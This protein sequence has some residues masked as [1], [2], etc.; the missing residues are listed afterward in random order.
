GMNIYGKGSWANSLKV[1]NGKFYVLTASLD[2]GKTYLFSTED[3]SG[4]W[5]RTEFNEYLHDPALFFDDDGKAYIIYGVEDFSIKELTAD[6]KAINP[7]GLNQVILTSGQ[8]GMEGAHVYKINGKYY[9]TA[10][11]WEQ[12]QIRRQY[13]YRSDQI[14]G[15]YEGRLALSDTMGR[16]EEHTSELQSRENLVCRLLLEKKNIIICQIT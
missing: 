9:I 11:W 3:P 6:Y 5:E 13:I 2:S 1:Y 8:P 10:I 14:I 4:D 15:P 12:G 7:N 16:S